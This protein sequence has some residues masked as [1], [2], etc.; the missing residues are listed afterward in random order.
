M[1]C[2]S[3]DAVLALVESIASGRTALE[4]GDLDWLGLELE[5]LRRPSGDAGAWA[6]ARFVAAP[7]ALRAATAWFTIRAEI[8]NG[9]ID[10]LAWNQLA[11]LPALIEALRHIGAHHTAAVLTELGAAA[12][13][14]DGDDLDAFL[15]VRRRVGGPWPTVPDDADAPEPL[16]EI[17]A[18]LIAHARARPA[19]F[20][21]APVETHAWQHGDRPHRTTIYRRPDGALEV[22]LAT[23]TDGGVWVDVPHRPCLVGADELAGARRLAEDLRAALAPGP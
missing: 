15:D 6:V 5:H 10:Q 17:Y 20:V 23:T 19:E 7:P 22:V 21:L 2:E 9:G 1:S 11:I 12:L 4:P 13:R 14:E 18:A 3:V 8:R 16:A